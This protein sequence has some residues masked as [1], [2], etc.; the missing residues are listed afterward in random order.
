MGS[1]H[2]LRGGA[3]LLQ[4]E[5]GYAQTGIGDGLIGQVAGV[6]IAADVEA[7]F[8]E[9]GGHGDSPKSEWMNC[10]LDVSGIQ[11]GK[12]RGLPR[13]V[14]SQIKGESWDQG[15][16]NAVKRARVFGILPTI[17]RHNAICGQNSSQHGS[18][19]K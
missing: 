18:K 10:V 16:L 4:Y 3:H 17:F 15:R 6:E 14:L 9:G 5:F 19:A 8:L 11:L 1:H 12:S 2:G 13:V 7:T